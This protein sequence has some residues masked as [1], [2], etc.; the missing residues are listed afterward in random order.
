M[1]Q[2]CQNFYA[3][4]LILYAYHAT[5]INN[6]KIKDLPNETIKATGLSKSDL[7]NVTKTGVRSIFIKQSEKVTKLALEQP[8]RCVELVLKL[9]NSKISTR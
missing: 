2:V 4:L 8:Y 7:T 1:I 5:D 3:T 9:K 6:D